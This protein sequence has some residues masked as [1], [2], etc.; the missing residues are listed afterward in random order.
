[1]LIQSDSITSHHVSLDDLIVKISCP[2]WHERLFSF[3]A[4]VERLPLCKIP[5]TVVQDINV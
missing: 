3:G 1:L 4:L 5:S 2:Y